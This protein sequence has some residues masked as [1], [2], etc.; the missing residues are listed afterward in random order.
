MEWLYRARP[1]TPCWYSVSLIPAV[2]R[3]TIVLII[4]LC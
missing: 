1:R 3:T 4:A 2:D